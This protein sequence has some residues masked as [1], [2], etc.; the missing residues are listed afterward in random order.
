MLESNRS[1][2]QLGTLT[3]QNMDSAKESD[4]NNAGFPFLTSQTNA[5]K[6]RI[7]CQRI[8]EWT[9]CLGFA[10]FRTMPSANLLL[11]AIPSIFSHCPTYS[12]IN[13]ENLSGFLLIAAQSY[14]LQTKDTICTPALTDGTMGIKEKTNLINPIENLIKSN[15]KVSRFLH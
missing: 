9:A 12:E 14:D 15:K 8:E 5:V 1:K 6:Y 2:D 4:T 11:L 10:I 3:M 7:F 13:P